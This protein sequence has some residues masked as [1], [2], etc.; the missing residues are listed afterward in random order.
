MSN[1][2]NDALNSVEGNQQTVGGT[3]AANGDIFFRIG[4]KSKWD[5]SNPNYDP[6][7]PARYAV[8]VIQYTYNGTQQRFQKLYLRQGHEADYLMRPED[9]GA[10]ITNRPDAKKFSPYN[11]THNTWSGT[12]PVAVRGRLTDYPTKAGAFFQHSPNN[13][14]VYAYDPATPNNETTPTNWQTGFNNGWWNTVKSWSETCPTG[15]QRPKDGTTTGANTAGSVTGSEM[16]QSL[17]QNPVA[18]NN[19]G[20]A[21]NSVWGY[22]ADGFFDRRPIGTQLAYSGQIANTA[23]NINT[24][25]V[26]YIGRLFYNSTTSASLFFPA[27]GYRFYSNGYLYHTGSYGYY[28]SSSASSTTYGWLLRVHAGGANQYNNNRL[29]GYSVRCVRE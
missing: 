15:Y 13:G 9:A 6:A 12:G 29:N 8:V 23:V 14:F 2:A 11:L 21:D 10:G 16:R 20:N 22:Y 7:K 1:P 27:A 19:V 4:L 28:W 3:V 17:W 18:G 25:E 24:T 26:A 5:S